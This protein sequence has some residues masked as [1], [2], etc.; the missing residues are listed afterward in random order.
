M[1]QQ[2]SL[3]THQLK[4]YTTFLKFFQDTLG[5]NRPLRKE[6]PHDEILDEL[7]YVKEMGFK[8]VGKG[9]LVKHALLSFFPPQL[10]NNSL[11]LLYLYKKLI[12]GE[13]PLTNRSIAALSKYFESIKPKLE[14][15]I[16]RHSDSAEDM[17]TAINI[18]L[19]ENK[20]DFYFNNYLKRIIFWADTLLEDDYTILDAIMDDFWI[21]QNLKYS[22]DE[23]YMI[24]AISQLFNLHK[25]P[26]S[27][28]FFLDYV[29]KKHD[30]LS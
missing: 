14:E 12:I 17:L 1:V 23:V 29:K 13:T 4:T 3:V 28:R 18:M 24:L 8:K 15:N 16:K 2:K 10:R 5:I 20:I 21:S 7:K 27:L 11:L 25:I 30:I 26:F 22:S 19:P 6:I 9:I